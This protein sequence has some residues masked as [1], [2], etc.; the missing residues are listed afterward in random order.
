MK[1]LFSVMKALFAL[2]LIG[3]FLCLGMLIIFFVIAY[4]HG[5]RVLLT[6]PYI[7]MLFPIFFISIYLTMLLFIFFEKPIKNLFVFLLIFG[8]LFYFLSEMSLILYIK[9]VA[10]SKYEQEVHPTLQ[11]HMFSEY[12][13]PHA[14]FKKDGKTFIWSF[15]ENDFVY[16][17][18]DYIKE[19]K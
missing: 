1:L 12:S 7:Y 15:R 13:D 9:Y 18:S 4:L 16:Y 8:F 5:L 17:Y 6:A 2:L 11:T 14:K 3:F 19:K 10:Y